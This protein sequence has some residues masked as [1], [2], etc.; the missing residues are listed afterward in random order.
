MYQKNL[1]FVLLFDFYGVLLTEKQ[2]DIFD[3]YYN[4]D[5][6]LSEIAN[7]HDVSRQGVYDIIKRTEALLIKWESNLK[8]AQRF[9]EQQEKLNEVLDFIK[10]SSAEQKISN[11]IASEITQLIEAL[12]VI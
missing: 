1:D 5:Y 7:I 9:S 12:I 2:K 8:L 4:N 11:N 10:T 6:S 3:M